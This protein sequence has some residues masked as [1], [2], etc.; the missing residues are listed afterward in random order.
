MTGPMGLSGL[1]TP[2]SITV[3]ASQPGTRGKLMVV[4]ANDVDPTQHMWGLSHKWHADG[5]CKQEV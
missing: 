4:V 3:T 5:V 1:N 2:A